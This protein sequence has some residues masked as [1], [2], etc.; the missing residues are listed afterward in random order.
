MRCLVPVFVCPFQGV[1]RNVRGKVK[2]AFVKAWEDPQAEQEP[3]IAHTHKH[4]HT[5]THTSTHTQAI[6][7]HTHTR[8]RTH[9]SKHTHTHTHTHTLY[10]GA[11]P[12]QPTAPNSGAW[13]PGLS[14]PS[15]PSPRPT[16]SAYSQPP[17][18]YSATPSP[19]AALL[20]GGLPPRFPV[21]PAGYGEWVD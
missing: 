21:T 6:H 12:S 7:K 20:S 10:T 11:L 3:S 5:R 14:G 18:L 2:S 9:T 15:L 4:T 8:T 17:P 1:R 16:P 19:H 13:P